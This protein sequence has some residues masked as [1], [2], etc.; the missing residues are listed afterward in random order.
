M[1][2]HFEDGPAALNGWLY[3]EEI[4][5]RVANEYTAA[6]SALRLAA[7]RQ[8]GD[9]ARV[10]VSDV[11]RRLGAFAA[12]HSLLRPPSAPGHVD[13]AEHL[14]KL[15]A[16]I[17]FA[18]FQ[19]QP[20]GLSIRTARPILLDA[21]RCWQAGL[22]VS[23]LITNAARHAFRP[24]HSGGEIT[25]T[26]TT[27]GGQVV[28][29]VNDTGTGS[30]NFTPGLGTAIVD[31]LAADLGGHVVRRSDASGTALELAFPRVLASDLPVLDDADGGD[32]SPSLHSLPGARAPALPM[33]GA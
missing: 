29:R 28:C 6:I 31:S 8:G 17:A 12:V 11:A 27:A 7:A 16:A 10:A 9:E 14:G 32:L 23:E 5:H 13:L 24:D 2:R 20:I 25:V 1:H 33:L 4:T 26:L 21:H 19:D 3:I 30:P 22:V 18:R 15:C